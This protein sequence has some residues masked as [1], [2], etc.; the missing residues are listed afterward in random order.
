MSNLGILGLLALVLGGTSSK[1]SPPGGI[2]IPYKMEPGPAPSLPVSD[3]ISPG[4]PN[5]PGIKTFQEEVTPISIP[6]APPA[7]IIP[8]ISPAAPPAAVISPVT[9]PRAIRSKATGW[10]FFTPQGPIESR[11]QTP[12]EKESGLGCPEVPGAWDMTKNSIAQWK[13]CA[14]PECP[15]NKRELDPGTGAYLEPTPAVL[16]Q[17]TDNAGNISY[18]CP[19]CRNRTT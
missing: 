5:I 13:Y 3:A 15:S 7:A 16:Q 11:P 12:E 9:T 6:A 18:Y 10:R 8:I 19:V 1:G 4:I 17:E 2:G 14:N